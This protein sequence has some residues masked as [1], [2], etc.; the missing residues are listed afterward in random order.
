MSSQNFDG[1]SVPLLL[2][3]TAFFALISA[4]AK[5]FGSSP[6]W[7]LTHFSLDGSLSY[8][9]IHYDRLTVLIYCV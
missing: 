4:L 7:T 9:R 8:C 1:S 3:S 2:K 6:E 5:T